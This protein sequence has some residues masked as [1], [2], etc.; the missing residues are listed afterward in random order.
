MILFFLDMSIEQ[1][2][3]INIVD[4][5]VLLND[6]FSPDGKFVVKKNL[7]YKFDYRFKS[8]SSI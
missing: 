7:S 2:L 3:L 6:N 8:S 1:T 4:Q 5:I